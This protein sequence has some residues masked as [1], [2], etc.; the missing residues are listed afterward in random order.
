MTVSSNPGGTGRRRDYLL[1]A[2]LVLTAVGGT[3]LALP[4]LVTGL[5]SESV[6]ADDGL[7]LIYVLYLSVYM[8]VAA[9]VCWV[10]WLSY[11]FRGRGEHPRQRG[12]LP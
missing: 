8:L 5:A 4:F 11:W 6:S 12:G 2:C 7:A 1:V 10:V 3:L 9:A